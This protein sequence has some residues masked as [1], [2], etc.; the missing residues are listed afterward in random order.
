MVRLKRLFDVDTGKDIILSK[1]SPGEFNVIGQ[2]AENNGVAGTTEQLT[3][4]KLYKKDEVI[5]VGTYG[6]L[7]ATVQLN[8]FYI[9]TRVKALLPKAE[10]SLNML[11]Y[12]A[13]CH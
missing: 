6:N 13:L 9:G 3:G 8:D 5:T 4:H 12:Y 1:L 10:M 11:K 2:S 7:Y